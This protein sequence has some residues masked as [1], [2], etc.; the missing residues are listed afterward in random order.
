MGDSETGQISADAAKI[1]DELYLP[2][3][4]EE[5]CPMVVEAAQIKEGHRV[6]DIACGTGA[7]AI[8]ILDRIGAQGSIVGIDINEGMLD[9]AKLKSSRVEWLNAPA[10]ALPFGDDNFDCAVSQFGLM[11]FEDRESALREMMRVVQPGGTLAI[12]VWDKLE[13]NPGFAAEER[14]WQHVFG[15]EAADES[16]NNLGDKKTLQNLF[17]GSGMPNAEIT[18]R[19]ATAHY[20]SIENWILAGARGWTEDDAIS[21]EKL[22]L[23]LKTAEIELADFRTADGTVAFSTSAHIVTARK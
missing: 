10:E 5:W 18:T 19:G 4:F 17:K 6:I 21:D 20:S 13:N 2:A 1:Y 14:L 22:D 3:L 16:P 23:L 8:A 9:V 15:G 12:V 11:Y 7:L